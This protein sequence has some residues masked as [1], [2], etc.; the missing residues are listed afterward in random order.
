MSFGDARRSRER[1]RSR[2]FGEG[3]RRLGERDLQTRP[4]V[5]C[6]RER[7]QLEWVWA[8]EG[9]SCRPLPSEREGASA[10]GR[11][12]ERASVVGPQRMGV[13]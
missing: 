7:A 2:F 9:V 5:S 3:E 8:R 10:V 12:R 6:K 11:L 1:E 4:R 13:S